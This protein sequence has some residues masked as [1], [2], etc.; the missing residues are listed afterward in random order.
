MAR[1][2]TFCHPLFDAAMPRFTLILPPMLLLP[3]IVAAAAAFR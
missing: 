2:A 1:Y 3:V